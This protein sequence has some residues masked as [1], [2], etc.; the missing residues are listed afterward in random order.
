M[1]AA[2]QAVARGLDRS[3]RGNTL[4]QAT[5]AFRP[6]Y[7]LAPPVARR[8]KLNYSSDLTV[9][10]ASGGWG[11]GGAASVADAGQVG[12]NGNA[13]QVITYS[14]VTSLANVY[15][16][17]VPVVAGQTLT[18]S[19]WIK[20]GSAPNMTLR[21]TDGDG[22]TIRGQTLVT[23]TGSFVRYQT[24]PALMTVTGNAQ[25]SL[26]GSFTAA[27]T[28]IVCDAQ[29]EQA[30]TPSAF[31][32][33]LSAYEYYETG[34]TSNG[35][36][37]FDRADDAMAATIAA[38]FT[39]DELLIGRNGYRPD[40]Q[41]LRAARRQSGGGVKCVSHVHFP[42]RQRQTRMR[43]Q[44]CCLA[45]NTTAGSARCDTAVGPCHRGRLTC[46]PCKLWRRMARRAGR[47][48]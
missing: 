33:T 6:I 5:G 18:A 4:L 46:R 36:L 43:W 27:G 17:T 41:L 31:Q 39:G 42:W 19:I 30:S 22:T 2:A 28:V 14:G 15:Q 48:R 23:P 10:A 38:G 34:Y 1:T 12:P 44:C 29:F 3:G 45:R 13:A 20:A 37:Y 21:F 8:N 24:P 26:R 7:S 25:F 9:P 47:P 35:G 32:K 11:K 16:A 40:D